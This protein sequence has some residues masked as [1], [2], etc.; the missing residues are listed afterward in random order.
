MSLEK[1]KV[2][3][4]VIGILV[5]VFGVGKYFYD[6]NLEAKKDR[7]DR[8]LSFISAYAKQPVRSALDNYN[9]TILGLRA[10]AS[11]Q[12]MSH[13]GFS[14]LTYQYLM[15]PEAHDFRYSV[16]TLQGFFSEIEFCVAENICD[17]ELARSHFCMIRT[18]LD[19]P[20]DAANGYFLTQ[21]LTLV[22]V[23]NEDVWKN[24]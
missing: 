15:Q 9:S 12:P 8:T 17:G 11:R 10:S 14:R 2:I 23:G 1:I 21:G 22:H 16:T 5:A 24:C 13:K 20:F 6:Q 7:K 3:S 18:S 19:L 4:Q